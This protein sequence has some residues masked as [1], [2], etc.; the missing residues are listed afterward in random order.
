MWGGYAYR[1]ANAI[2]FFVAPRGRDFLI[3]HTKV[4]HFLDSR[5]DVLK[6]GVDVFVSGERGGD[7]R[8]DGVPW[9]VREGE[10]GGPSAQAC[11]LSLELAPKDGGALVTL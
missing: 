1:R 7:A 10:S 3:C 4:L 9:D 2:E 8:G 5:P 6:P 11:R